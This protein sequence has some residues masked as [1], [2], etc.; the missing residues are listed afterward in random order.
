MMSS[1]ATEKKEHRLRRHRRIRTRVRGTAECPR[2]SVFKSNRY[3]SAQL[4][5]DETHQTLL[6][7]STQTLKGA[8]GSKSER[9]RMLGVVIAKAAQDLKIK[10]I[11]FD[12][13]GFPYMGTVRA[14]AEGAREGGL[15]F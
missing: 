12:R 8:T 11:V 2:L 5:N 7:M 14:F 6:G 10:G 15:V 1:I 3:V 9:A 13:G 4:V